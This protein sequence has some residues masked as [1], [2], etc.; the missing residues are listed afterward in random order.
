MSNH[1]DHILKQVNSSIDALS[2]KI[3][4]HY[5]DLSWQIQYEQLNAQDAQDDHTY[6]INVSFSKAHSSILDLSF[7]L[8]GDD[9][10][11]IDGGLVDDQKLLKLLVQKNIFSELNSSMKNYLLNSKELVYYSAVRLKSMMSFKRDSLSAVQ[12]KMERIMVQIE[13]VF[14]AVMSQVN[15]QGA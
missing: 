7:Y 6:K 10:L 3:K 1:Q 9:N 2:K 8:D 4:D 5:P 14:I 12:S 15:L 13:T 11:L